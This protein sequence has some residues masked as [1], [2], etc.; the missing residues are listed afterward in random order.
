MTV[1]VE[2]AT[3]VA[4]T[5]TATVVADLDHRTSQSRRSPRMTF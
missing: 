2:T 3:V 1:V 4:A 5:A